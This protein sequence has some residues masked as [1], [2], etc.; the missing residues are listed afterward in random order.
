MAIQ[1][2]AL[3]YRP[4]ALEPHMSVRTL[5]FHYGKH[6]RAYVDNINAAAIDTDLA[7]ADLVTIIKTARLRGDGKLFNNSA[8]IFWRRKQRSIAPIEGIGLRLR[9]ITNC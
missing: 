6:H 1:L 4:D 2:Q 5:E 8:Q 7:Y 9:I 3:P